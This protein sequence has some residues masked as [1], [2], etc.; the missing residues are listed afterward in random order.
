MA[1]QCARSNDTWAFCGKNVLYCPGGMMQCGNDPKGIVI[2]G[3]RLESCK[4]GHYTTSRTHESR[5]GR[6]QEAS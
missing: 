5:K 4:Q 3:I 6:F 2:G 1:V